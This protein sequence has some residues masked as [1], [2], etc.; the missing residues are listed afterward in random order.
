MP[1]TSVDDEQAECE[2]AYAYDLIACLD[3]TIK[4]KIN[5]T[6]VDVAKHFDAILP[7]IWKLVTEAATSRE[8]G[9]VWRNKRLLA[10]IARLSDRLFWT[11]D[12]EYVH[13]PGDWS[14]STADNT[15]NRHKSSAPSTL[16]TK[17]VIS[18]S[19][20]LRVAVPLLYECVILL[21]LHESC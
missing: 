9:Q 3:D 16:S 18:P 11:L 6:N 15:V 12:A 7:K 1:T 20:V 2:V 21:A 13:G 10:I 14:V 5:A 17:R 8:G 19:S 4:R